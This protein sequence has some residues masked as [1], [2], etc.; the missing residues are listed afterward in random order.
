MIYPFSESRPFTA[1]SFA[2]L[3]A[4]STMLVAPPAWSRVG[5]ASVVEGQ[6]LGKPPQQNERVLHVGIDMDADER[7]T[8][9]AEDRAHLVFNDG[10]SVT[11]GPNS[12]VVIDKYVFDPAT[13]KGDMSL[14]VTKGVLRF[15]GGAISKTS[16]VK[17]TTPSATLGIRGG[18]F[19]VAVS[20]TGATS[21]NFMFG[22]SLT[23]TSQGVTRTTT[24]FGTQIN[25]NQGSPPTPPAPIPPAV[26]QN[27]IAL[28]QQ[29]GSQQ[30]V[31][32]AQ[33]FAQQVPPPQAANS[34]PQTGGQ[35]QQGGAPRGAAPTQPGARSGAG[36]RDR[37]STRLNSSHIPLSR[38]PS[39]A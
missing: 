1:R 23:V 13:R 17:V 15:V 9:N 31:A 18:I 8:T 33:G 30:Y 39:S 12:Q 25:V 20:P 5:V 27:N 2:A 7:V 4:M 19:Q 35:Q 16:E 21:A 34:P 3:L 32:P 14:T 22:Q 29:G 6:P 38:M 10:S 28:F 26:M 36:P 11:I 37:K 24:S